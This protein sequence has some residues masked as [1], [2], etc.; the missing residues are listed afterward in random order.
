[1]RYTKK[2]HEENEKGSI[3]DLNFVMSGDHKFRPNHT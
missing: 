2:L 1:M 3:L